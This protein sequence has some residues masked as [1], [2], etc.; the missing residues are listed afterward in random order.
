MS[1]TLL[2][3]ERWL[4]LETPLGEDVLVATEVKGVEAISTLFEFTISSNS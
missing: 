1:N 4:T 3:A 2:Q